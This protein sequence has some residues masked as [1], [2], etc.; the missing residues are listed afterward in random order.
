[1]TAEEEVI[2]AAAAERILNEKIV[3]DA[4]KDI[5]EDIVDRIALCSTTET[6]LR[7]KLCMMLSCSRMFKSVFESHIQTGK[8]A[9][10][11]LKEKRF[12]VF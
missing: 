5:E 8:M 6:L 10:L 4:F 7:E 2:R 12:K 11:Q 9:Q 1:M 3:K